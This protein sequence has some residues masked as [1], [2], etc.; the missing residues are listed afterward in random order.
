MSRVRLGYID[1]LN[2]LPVYY[3]LE[4]GAVPMPAGIELVKDVPAQ[5]NRRLAAGELDISAMSSIEYARNADKLV[6][7]PDLSINSAGFVH[8]VYL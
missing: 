4:T 8:S 1:F 6:L 3:G 5:L 7:L 2:S